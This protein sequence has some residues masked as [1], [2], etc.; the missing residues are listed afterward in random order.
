MKKGVDSKISLYIEKEL[1]KLF[2]IILIKKEKT[3]IECVNELISD[4]VKKNK[5]LL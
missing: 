3:V 2:K 1:Y 5:D 4:Y